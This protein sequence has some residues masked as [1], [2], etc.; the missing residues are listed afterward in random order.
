MAKKQKKTR[1]GTFKELLTEADWEK[2]EELFTYG[3][4][5]SEVASYFGMHRATLQRLVLDRY[6]F[7]TISEVKNHFKPKGHALIREAQFRLVADGNPATVIFMSKAVLGMTEDGGKESAPTV[8]IKQADGSKIDLS[9]FKK[10]KE[11]TEDD[12][13]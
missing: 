6:G 13:D 10:K 8:I 3:C 4:S 5:G 7:E 9:G 1:K 11:D 2:I 12:N